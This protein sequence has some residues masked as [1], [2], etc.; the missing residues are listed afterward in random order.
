MNIFEELAESY[1]YNGVVSLKALDDDIVTL[2]NQIDSYN[3]T[4]RELQLRG[5]KVTPLVAKIRDAKIR[6]SLLKAVYKTNIKS[7]KIIW[8]F[9]SIVHFASPADSIPKTPESSA[10]CC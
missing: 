7:G 10:F 2:E 3:A 9:L 1:T 6:L 5:K 4:L 8:P